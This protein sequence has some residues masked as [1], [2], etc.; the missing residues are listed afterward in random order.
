M[1]AQA[2]LALKV[3]LE[4][5]KQEAPAVDSLVVEGD[6][7]ER[8]LSAAR[9]LDADMIAMGTHARR[10]LSRVFMGSVAE[11]VVRTSEIPVLT[12]SADAEEAKVAAEAWLA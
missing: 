12:T 5:A 3:E 7:R 6:P 1:V 10:G 11:A 2:K 8:I 4:L 9:E